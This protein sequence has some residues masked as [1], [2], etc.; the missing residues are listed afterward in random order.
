MSAL[1]FLL[2][3]DCYLTLTNLLIEYLLDS[4]QRITLKA[5]LIPL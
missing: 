1:T 3:G 4:L 5:S 2:Q